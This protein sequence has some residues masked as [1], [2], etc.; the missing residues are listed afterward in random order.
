MTG[1]R[2]RTAASSCSA[3]REY[4]LGRAFFGRPTVRV[5]RDLLGARLRVRDG[6][7]TRE[8]V[9]VETEAYVAHDAASHAARGPT[10]RNRSMFGPP[11]T[12]YVFRIHQ[13]V[14]ANLVTQ[15]GEAVLLR[16]AAV[17]GQPPATASGPGKLCRAL[18]ITIDDDGL[19][20]VT[21]RRVQ[22]L[23]RTSRAPEIR[24]GP[25]VGIRRAA[26]RRLRFWVAG[27]P[28]V[29]RPRRT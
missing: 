23:A 6:R 13:V 29:S 11:G 24:V 2:S 12:L 5:A 7:R 26:E 28:S 15:V 20:A 27:E 21:G 25:R 10:R 18:G 4:R 9:L 19:D 3:G 16:A 1:T 17:P 14:C 8:A 22:L